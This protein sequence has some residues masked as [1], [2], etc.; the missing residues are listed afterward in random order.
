[1]AETSM[2][3]SSGG[4]LRGQEEPPVASRQEAINGSLET[5]EE[6]LKYHC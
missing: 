5:A 2:S 3:D 1:M 6:R 4:S